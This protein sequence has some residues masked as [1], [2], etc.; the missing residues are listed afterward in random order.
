MKEA[1]APSRSVK[2]GYTRLDR[3]SAGTFEGG[4]REWMS[5]DAAQQ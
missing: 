4:F 3:A 1:T 2:D 5:G